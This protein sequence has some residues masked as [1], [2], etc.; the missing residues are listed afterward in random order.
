[1]LRGAGGIDG[2]TGQAGAPETQRLR[3]TGSVTASSL[4]RLRHT[5]TLAGRFQVPIT[6]DTLDGRDS[7]ACPLV[8]SKAQLFYLQSGVPVGVSKESRGERPR[9]PVLK[10]T[11]QK[12]TNGLELPLCGSIW[13]VE[14]NL[15]TLLKFQP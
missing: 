11:I 6:E 14:R 1:M 12:V 15:Q 2:G 5:G 10:K 13:P 8:A 7:S 4:D 3:P 9:E